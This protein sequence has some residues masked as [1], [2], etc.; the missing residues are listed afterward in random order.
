MIKIKKGE[1]MKQDRIIL[2]LVLM[3]I[4]LSVLFVTGV[5]YA[6][7]DENILISNGCNTLELYKKDFNVVF[8][9]E[10]TYKGDGVAE[11]AI[12]GPRTATINITELEKVGDTITT[13]FTLENKSDCLYADINAEVT[14]T[15][16]EYFNVT[17][18]LTDNKISPKNGKINIEIDVELIKLPIYEEKSS[19]S[20]NIFAEP[21][22]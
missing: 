12:T 22:N 1:D 2:L 5:G 20:V 15:N 14:N 7:E 4:I 10:P 21:I 8:S 13:I 17:S 3:V 18:R 9:G 16:T 6:V 11:L 19:I